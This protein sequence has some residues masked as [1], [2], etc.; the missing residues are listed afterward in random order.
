MKVAEDHG[1]AVAC[2]LIPRVDAIAVTAARSLNERDGLESGV[3]ALAADS[4]QRKRQTKPSS[5]IQPTARL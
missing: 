1:C 2:R 5:V 3:A 4:R